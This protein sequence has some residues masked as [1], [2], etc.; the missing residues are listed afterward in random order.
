M[1]CNNGSGSGG[2]WRVVMVVVIVV[3]DGVACSNGGSR[4]GK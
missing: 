3:V 2:K 4:R 1:V